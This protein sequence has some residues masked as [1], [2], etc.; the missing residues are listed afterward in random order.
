MKLNRIP[1]GAASWL[2]TGAAEE[3]NLTQIQLAVRAGLELEITRF[4]VQCPIHSA[5][6]PPEIV[7]ITSH[8]IMDKIP[9]INWYKGRLKVYKNVEE[10]NVKVSAP[11]V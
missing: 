5:R 10:K 11:F 2:F 8:L 9:L 6:L 7:D 1:T 4:Q 3:L